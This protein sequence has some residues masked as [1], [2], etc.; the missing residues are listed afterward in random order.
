[1]KSQVYDIVRRIK[2]YNEGF[3]QDLCKHGVREVVLDGHGH[4]VYEVCRSCGK[5][6]D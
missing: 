1:M 4:P 5:R 2:E 3:A 6:F